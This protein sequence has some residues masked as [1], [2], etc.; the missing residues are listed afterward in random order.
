MR[1]AESNLDL[2]LEKLDGMYRQ[3]SGE[4][5]AQAFQHLWT[6]V[7]EVERTPEWIEPLKVAKSLPLKNREGWFRNISVW[8]VAELFGS[9]FFQILRTSL[10]NQ[11]L[12]TREQR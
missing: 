6:G 2:F 12:R 1:R 8:S 4:T 11:M 9:F 7:Y 5:L 10:E 3:K